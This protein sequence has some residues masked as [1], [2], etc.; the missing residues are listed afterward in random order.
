MKIRNK[1]LLLAAA[2]LVATPAVANAKTTVMGGPL[3]NI[4]AGQ[5]V[6]IA[7]SGY[8]T[9][10]LYILECVKPADGVR[11]TLCNQAAQL[12]IT[13]AQGGSFAPT[14]DIQFKP[15]AQF[16]SGTTAVDCTKDICG[17]FVRLDHT[18]PTD[19]SEDQFIPLTFAA[20]TTTPAVTDVVTA[21]V[22]GKDLSPAAPLEVKYRDVFT[23]VGASKAGAALTYAS[24]APACAISGNQVTVL[25]G[26][27]YCDIAITSAAGTT[28]HFPLKLALGVQAVTL[29]ASGK[30]GSTITLP[31]TTN[32]GEKI[33][34]SVT[35][36]KNCS[37]NGDKLKLNK[38]G[39]CLVKA[40]APGVADN[41]SAL[42]TSAT[43][44]IK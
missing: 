10:G 17:I 18:A 24:L 11:P 7:L 12:W 13:T 20:S 38:K 36:S 39:A 40:T 14:A 35:K 1:A 41:Y 19:T 29:K 23:V 16:T 28:A 15:T 4:A 27:G 30:A 33:T 37:L 21:T 3:T 9:A 22:N 44:T 34:Y 6:H 25:K 8:P 43:I 31:A 42:K 32:F 26:T 2:L 5:T